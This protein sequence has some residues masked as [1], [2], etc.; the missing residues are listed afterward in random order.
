MDNKELAL[1]LT[2]VLAPTINAGCSAVEPETLNA[3]NV[4]GYYE[5]ILKILNRHDERNEAS[6]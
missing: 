6:E 1:G 4:I 2:Q 3:C 5:E